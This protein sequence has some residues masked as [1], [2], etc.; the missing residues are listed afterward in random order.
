MKDFNHKPVMLKECI[1]KLKIKPDGIYIDGTI[2]GAGHSAEIYKRL[3]ENGILIGIDQDEVALRVSRKRLTEIEGRATLLLVN[4]NF[5]NIKRICLENEI[6]EVDGILMDLGVSSYQLDEAK[7]GF[8]YR[9]NAQ[10]DMRMDRSKGLNAEII[11]N[12]YTKEDLKGIISKYGE[13]K[14]ASRIAEFI[15]DS[16][17]KKRIKTTSELVEI[18]KAAIPSS[19][20]REGPHPAKRTF[21]ALR[22]AV[23]D[24]LGALKEAIGD[25]INLLKPG[26]R[27]CIITF[28]S[29]EDR[30]VKNE[31]KEKADPCKCPKSFPVC[32]CG[33]KPEIKVITKKPI[34]PLAEE[35][36]QN[37]RARSA[38]LRVAEKI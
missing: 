7:R 22:I 12:E 15:V 38:K 30:I 11:V 33:M 3:N 16:R 24:E 1:E 18:I 31:F 29:L 2:G 20:R 35:L 36:K 8:S 32:V 26:G 5:R 19:A 37:P 9:K 34:L 4:S 6:E 28:H 25:A 10:L 21:Q 13:E 27:L 23:N 17:Q 14:W